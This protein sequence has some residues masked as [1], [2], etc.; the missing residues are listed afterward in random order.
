MPVPA[1]KDSAV[2]D[3]ILQ[4]TGAVDGKLTR[5]GQP[6]GDTVVIANPVGAVSSN[7]FIV[8]GPDG[9]FVLDALTPGFYFI[10][11][12]IGGGGNR[13]K[14]MVMRTV[15]VT[16]GSRARIDIDA[17]P[18]KG[19]LTV[20]IKT[21]A[22]QPVAMAMVFT[23]QAKIDAPNLEAL[24]DGS[25]LP[26]EMRNGATVMMYIRN[27]MG[28]PA[29]IEEMRPG[30]YT[31]CVTPLPIGDDPSLARSV[32]EDADQLPMKCSPAKVAAAATQLDVEVPAAWTEKRAARP[33]P[34]K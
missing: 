16:A 31:V 17:T 13:D 28:K 27:A 8:T 15:E 10:T 1:S 5:S 20:A 30:E 33:A 14:D 9:S 22:G 3:L 29:V 23:V 32:A 7:F 25:F 21:D 2:V 4:P 34:A 18:G 12:L 26:P 24:R 11:P 19:Q 6:L